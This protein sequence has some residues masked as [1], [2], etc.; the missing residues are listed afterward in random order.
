MQNRGPVLLV[1]V[2]WPEGAIKSPKIKKTRGADFLYICNAQ[3]MVVQ[4]SPG[5]LSIGADYFVILMF[6]YLIIFNYRVIFI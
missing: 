1:I 6:I 5:V 4:Y 2:V 3:K